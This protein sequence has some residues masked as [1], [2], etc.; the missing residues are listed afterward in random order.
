MVVRFVL[1]VCVS[2]ITGAPVCITFT[3]EALSMSVSSMC[4]VAL[5]CIVVYSLGVYVGG[6][7]V[8]FDIIKSNG[9]S[10]VLVVHFA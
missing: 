1:C 4:P 2:V 8:V 5:L 6:L 7:R 3:L 9:V 10:W